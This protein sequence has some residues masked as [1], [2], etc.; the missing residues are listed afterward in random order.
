MPEDRCFRQVQRIRKR[1]HFLRLYQEADRFHTP[2][3]VLYICEN[4]LP[5]S[6]LGITVSR[7]IGKPV[8]RNRI[9]RRLREI[10]RR[11]WSDLEPAADLIVNAKRLASRAAFRELR[12]GLGRAVRNW[13]QKREDQ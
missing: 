13:R 5:Q 10:F 3:F 7:K 2:F 9:K 4:G 11:D 1:R 8:V 6:R 12:S